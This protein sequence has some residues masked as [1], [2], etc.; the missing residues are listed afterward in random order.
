MNNPTQYPQP[1]DILYGG[2]VPVP[3]IEDVLKY[4]VQP[5]Y[6]MFF[7]DE[8]ADY[9]YSKTRHS[10]QMMKAEY[11]AYKM[12]EVD[13]ES[14]LPENKKFS[15]YATVDQMNDIVSA[16]TELTKEVAALKDTR[17]RNYKPKQRRKNHEQTKPN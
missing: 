17:S 7:K 8:N 1:P 2:L 16:M 11:K 13:F 4:P 6:C 10:S 12:D 9:I 3:S 15:N 14:L 5:G